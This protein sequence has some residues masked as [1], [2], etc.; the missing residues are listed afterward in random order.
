LKNHTRVISFKVDDDVYFALKKIIATKKLSFRS[1]FEP[2]AVELAKNN[3]EGLKYTGVY[4]KNYD[5]L[6]INLI[7][8][9]KTLD[10]IIK[11]YDNNSAEEQKKLNIIKK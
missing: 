11:L 6:Y 2:L 4:H 7:H 1:L 9:Q 10:K 5:D 3:T 8:L